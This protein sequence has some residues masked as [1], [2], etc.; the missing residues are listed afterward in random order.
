MNN[1]GLCGQRS[2]M[3]LWEYGGKW[4]SLC[5]ECTVLITNL[6]VYQTPEEFL[7]L[8]KHPMYEIFRSKILGDT[9]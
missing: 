8:V 9:G 7:Q 4:N 5:G 3:P 1:C 6:A 2:D